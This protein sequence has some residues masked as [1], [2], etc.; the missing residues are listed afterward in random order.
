[1]G[2]PSDVEWVRL[3]RKEGAIPAT[4]ISSAERREGTKR[5]PNIIPVPVDHNLQEHDG[6]DRFGFAHASP[7]DPRTVRLLVEA[8]RGGQRIFS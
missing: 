6:S 1:M 7:L 5:G 2:K 3:L 8:R 4:M